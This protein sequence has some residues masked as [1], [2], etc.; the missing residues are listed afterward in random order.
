MRLLLPRLL[1]QASRHEE[2]IVLHQLNPLF[3][4]TLCRCTAA[5]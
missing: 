5:T 4:A 3:S 1:P 2:A